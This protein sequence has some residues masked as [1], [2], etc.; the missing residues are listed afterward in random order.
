MIERV[1]AANGAEDKINDDDNDRS[2]IGELSSTKEDSSSVSVSASGRS[3]KSRS[4]SSG[5]NS[6]EE[7]EEEVVTSTAAPD[8]TTTTSTASIT[9]ENDPCSKPRPGPPWIVK[10]EG[11]TLQ[12]E[13]R[14]EPHAELYMLLLNGVSIYSGTGT[15]FKAKGLNLRKCYRFQVAYYTLATTKEC[16]DSWSEL[17]VQLYVN[18]CT[19][20]RSKMCREG[21][22]VSSGTAQVAGSLEPRSI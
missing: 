3:S 19:S 8:V 15:S 1:R 7:K 14:A 5:S 9:K 10:K 22:C 6:S 13:W 12:I 16:K 11:D 20:I 2:V 4:S 17:G 21:G 18:D